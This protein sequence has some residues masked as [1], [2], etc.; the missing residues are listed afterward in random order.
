MAGDDDRDRVRA[1]RTTGGARGLLV[2]GLAG[3]IAVGR[4]LAV[5]H[6]R[7]RREDPP[8]ERGQRAQVHLDLE[9]APPA[10]EIFV[11]LGEQPVAPSPVGHDPGSVRSRDPRE[12]ALV[13]PR[14][15]VDREDTARADRDPERT[16]RRVHH[17]VTDGDQALAIRAREELGA[18]LVE[19]WRERRHVIFSL[20]FFVA[21]ATRDR[22]AA[23]LHSST[24]AISA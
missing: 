9:P 17:A 11:E 2:P 19:K 5:G 22:A 15:V 4:D 21:S 16:E 3:D 13:R 6:P 7:G 18:R 14:A 8:L 1:E 23:A 12:L 20:T 24:S 10:S